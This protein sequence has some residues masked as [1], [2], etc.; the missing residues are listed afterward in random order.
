MDRAISNLVL[1]SR[2]FTKLLSQGHIFGGGGKNAN[3]CYQGK[4]GCGHDE[5]DQNGC[6]TWIVTTE[7]TRGRVL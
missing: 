6:C 5:G 1:D 2:K 4:D 7:L 3:G